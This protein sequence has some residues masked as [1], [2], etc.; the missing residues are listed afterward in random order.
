M[1]GGSSGSSGGGVNTQLGLSETVFK[2]RGTADC[3]FTSGFVDGL[4]SGIGTGAMGTLGGVVLG[5]AGGASMSSGSVATFSHGIET[6]ERP[7]PRG[8]K[9]GLVGAGWKRG[10]L[11]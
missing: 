10:W 6:D 8:E 11:M 9:T 5:V 1:D 3:S 7:P 2:R 4:A